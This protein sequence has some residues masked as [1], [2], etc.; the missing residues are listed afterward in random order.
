MF[1]ICMYPN[2]DEG[3]KNI[4]ASVKALE[5]SIFFAKLGFRQFQAN[6]L[7]IYYLKTMAWNGLKTNE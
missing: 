4:K 3:R 6:I 7:F 1:A 2:K 5:Q